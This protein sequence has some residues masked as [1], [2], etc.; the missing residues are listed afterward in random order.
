[1][2]V[3]VPP[4][5]SP[6]GRAEAMGCL[7]LLS[8]HRKSRGRFALFERGRGTKVRA[9][10]LAG[11]GLGSL[12]VDFC[13]AAVGAPVLSFIDETEAPALLDSEQS[14]RAAFLEPAASG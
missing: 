7:A 12:R 14:R 11:G 1:M 3:Q 13:D 6:T 10:K 5:P 2:A 9:K 4:R 8:P